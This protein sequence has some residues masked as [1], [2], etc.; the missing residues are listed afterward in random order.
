MMLIK[1]AGKNW[2][3]QLMLL[4]LCNVFLT[5]HNIGMPY[6]IHSPNTDIELKNE[7]DEKV[8]VSAKNI[9][10]TR[11]GRTWDTIKHQLENIQRKLK[12]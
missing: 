12:Q 7:K 6:M 11:Q 2:F 10:R 8:K 9:Y 1:N 4:I 5:Y 3:Y